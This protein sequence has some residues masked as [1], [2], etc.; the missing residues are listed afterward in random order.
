MARG[1][2]LPGKGLPAGC[3]VRL[4]LTFCFAFLSATCIVPTRSLDGDSDLATTL[5]D[6]QR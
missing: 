5:L 1:L 2:A 3:G 6:L 4:A